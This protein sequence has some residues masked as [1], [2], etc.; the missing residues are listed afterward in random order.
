MSVDVWE[1]GYSVHIT[2]FWGWTPE[3]W[4]TVSYT[5]PSRVKTVINQTTD[6]F[7]VVIYVTKSAE[8]QG[9]ELRGKVVGFYFVSHQTGIRNAFTSVEHHNRHPEKWQHGLKAIRA[10]NFLPEFR[11]SIDEFDPT[12]K[13]RA[14]AVAQY[15]E[16]VSQA[17]VERLRSI[18]FVEVPVFGESPDVSAILHIP[19]STKN[20]VKGGPAIKSGYHVPGEPDDTEKEL[21]ALILEGNTKAYMG[22]EVGSRRIYKIGLSMSPA[23]RRD[24]LQK[25]LAQGS[26]RWQLYRTTRQDGDIAYSSFESALVGEEAIKDALGSTSEW[27]GGEFYLATGKELNNAWVMGREAALRAA[28]DS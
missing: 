15:G 14:Q 7:I 11:I 21:Y 6:P 4:G 24:A 23:T 10:F 25:A 12:I 19:E 28:G 1:R 8:N 26:F 9:P 27:L 13:R 18:P 17:A 3:T 16:Q 22:K 20:K 5:H 2:S